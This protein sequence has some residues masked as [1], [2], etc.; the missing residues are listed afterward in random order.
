MCKILTRNDWTFKVG[1]VES[2]ENTPH[3]I[4]NK[5]KVGEVAYTCSANRW[6]AKARRSG[7]QSQPQ[8]H[9][10]VEA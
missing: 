10:Q 8:L 9:S 2:K 6:E 1:K 7:V 5:I 3:N 4:Q